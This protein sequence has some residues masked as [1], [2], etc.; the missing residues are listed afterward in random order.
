[1]A[2][3]QCRRTS[4]AKRVRQPHQLIANRQH[5]H[6]IEI[7]YCDYTRPGQ[8]LEAAQRQ[9]AAL[10]KYISGK[11]VTLRTVLLVVGGT[12]YTEHTLNQCKQMGLDHQRAIQLARKLHAHS[13]MYTN[14]LVTT[15]HAIQNTNA[16]HSQVLEPDASSNPPDAPKHFLFCSIVVEGTNG[17]SDSMCLLYLS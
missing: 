13:V 8:Q 5:V 1:M 4:V 16:S 6:L 15:R 11:T 7:R 2:P 14:K 17:S 9:H 12:C 10:C 3:H